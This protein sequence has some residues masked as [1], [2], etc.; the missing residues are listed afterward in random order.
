MNAKITLIESNISIYEANLMRLSTQLAN[1]TDSRSE[2]T[3]RLI[4]Y[5]IE[6]IQQWLLEEH[7]LLDELRKEVTNG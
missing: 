2:N 1:A 5:Q 3:I 6:Q 7:N 4:E